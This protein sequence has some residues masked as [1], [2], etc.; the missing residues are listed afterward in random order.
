MKHSPKQFDMTASGLF[1]YSVTRINHNSE[2]LLLAAYRYHISI[3][4]NILILFFF[5]SSKQSFDPVST[6]DNT[7][8]STPIIR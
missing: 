6:V 3:T 8:L 2:V 5:N 7:P 4:G 1:C